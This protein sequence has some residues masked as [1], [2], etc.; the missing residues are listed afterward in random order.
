MLATTGEEASKADAADDGSSVAGDTEGKNM[1]AIPPISQAAYISRLGDKCLNESDHLM[2]R[3]VTGLKVIG[4]RV[5]M[6]V[7]P[8]GCFGKNRSCEG[9]WK[10]V[11]VKSREMDEVGIV[12]LIC[13]NHLL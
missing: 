11:N 3:P 12:M 4:G 7:R 8:I 5:W 10:A 6:Y 9:S 13:L 2:Q 1:P